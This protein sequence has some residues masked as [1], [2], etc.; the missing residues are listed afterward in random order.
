ME[1][2]M[3]PFFHRYFIITE[4]DSVIT[5][6]LFIF[7]MIILL[8]RLKFIEID[9]ILTTEEIQYWYFYADFLF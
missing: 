3:P 5:H 2:Y 6:V 7:Y 9:I 1:N 8:I 4:D